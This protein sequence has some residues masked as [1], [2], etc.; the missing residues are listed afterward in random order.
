MI[1]AT[2]T[3]QANL[4]HPS[5]PTTYA[6]TTSVALADKLTC[7]I[8][9]RNMTPTFAKGEPFLKATRF[10]QRPDC[11]EQPRCCHCSNNNPPPYP[12]LSYTVNVPPQ[13]T[14]A[15]QVVITTLS[16]GQIDRKGIKKFKLKQGNQSVKQTLKPT[17]C[18]LSRGF[19]PRKHRCRQVFHISSGKIQ[20]SLF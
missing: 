8:I 18:F 1:D 6:C 14:R 19:F 11:L 5:T 3:P 20:G 15:P 16:Y 9:P 13:R 4:T 12:S 17:H 7:W 10:Q 2:K